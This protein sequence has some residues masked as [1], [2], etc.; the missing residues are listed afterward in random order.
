MFNNID[1]I[2]FKQSCDHSCNS[3]TASNQPLHNTNGAS[4]Q[5]L[6]SLTHDLPV[7]LEDALNQR[8][9]N[10]AF[11]S[12]QQANQELTTALS[13]SNDGVKSNQLTFGAPIGFSQTHKSGLHQE[14]SKIS[15]RSCQEMANLSATSNQQILNLP[16]TQLTFNTSTT[17]RVSVPTASSVSMQPQ[18]NQYQSSMS[19]LGKFIQIG[20]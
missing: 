13:C 14:L 2:C 6:V 12:V 9:Q 19:N 7:S 17:H 4:V 20:Y 1:F 18:S 11:P 16:S 5:Q 8:V 3:G 10:T 15:V